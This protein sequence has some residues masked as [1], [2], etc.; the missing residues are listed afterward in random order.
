LQTKKI[1]GNNRLKRDIVL[2]IQN[3]TFK[4]LQAI[5]SENMR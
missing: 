1:L 2:Y 5:I 3:G 4:V